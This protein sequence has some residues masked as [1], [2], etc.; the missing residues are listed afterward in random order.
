MQSFKMQLVGVQEIKRDRDDRLD[1]LRLELEELT[2][3][4][5]R[6]DKEHT[7]L[8][9][10][11]EHV[12]EEHRAMKL[13]YESVSEKLRLA[14]RVR[15]EKEELLNE[16][17]KALHKMSENFQEKEHQVERLKKEVDK[18][19]KR[20]QDTELLNDAL[21]IK[22]RSIEKQ[23]EVQRR[24]LLEKVAALNDVIAAE[25]DTREVWINRFE[26]EQ[27]AHIATSN[28]LL[29]TKGVLQDA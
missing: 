2:E 8:R 20:L 12:T 28:E 13:D 18:L 17:M 14:N 9:V 3:R 21:E 11:H 25:K 7:A 23:A 29:H 27:K 4:H 19:S 5:D 6:L 15:N 26:K 16:K 24:Q 1:K 10:S 22:R